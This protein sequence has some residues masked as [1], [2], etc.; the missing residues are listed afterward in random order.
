MSPR[1]GLA[2]I[3]RTRLGRGRGSKRL[4]EY[5]AGRGRAQPDQR[6]DTPRLAARRP[7]MAGLDLAHD[8]AASRDPGRRSHDEAHADEH[9]HQHV[10]SRA[11]RPRIGIV[12]AGAVGT[13][14][15]RGPQP[16]PAGRSRPSPAGMR[17]GGSGSAGWSAAPGPSPTPRRSWTTSSSSSWPCPT[18]PSPRSPPALRLY[19]GQALV[20]TSGRARAEVLAPAMAAG[21]QIG[22]VPPARRLRRHGAGCR[23]APRRD[24]RGRGRRPAGGPAGRD[25]R[26]DRAPSRAAGRRAPSPPTTRRRS[27][28]PAAS[29]ALLDAIAELGRVA[30]LDEAGS[31]A[32]YRPLVEQTLGNAGRWASGPP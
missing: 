10:R 6:E 4:D 21:T 18:T 3:G 2:R 11:S 14:L 19:G 31:L 20:H 13:A 1:R 9:P 24:G 27:W 12:G 16:R 22:V 5:P 23:G 26:G 28:P 30:G 15:G 17:P 32:V 7:P 25:G 29:I 8:A